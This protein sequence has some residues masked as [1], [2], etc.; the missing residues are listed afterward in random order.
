MILDEIKLALA[1][2][3]TFHQT[4]PAQGRNLENWLKQANNLDQLVN[5]IAATLTKTDLNILLKRDYSHPKSYT[6]AFADWIKLVNWVQEHKGGQIANR[7]ISH[8]AAFIAK[9][10]VPGKSLATIFSQIRK[11]L[12]LWNEPH[13]QKSLYLDHWLKENSHLLQ[14][15]MGEISKPLIEDELKILL[16][17]SPVAS[18]QKNLAK[19]FWQQIIHYLNNPKIWQDILN[20]ASLFIK[21]PTMSPAEEPPKPSHSLWRWQ[22]LPAG[23]DYHPE[24]ATQSVALPHGFKLIAARVRGKKHKHEGTHC[25]DWF[26]ITQ[27]GPWGIIAVADG[28][29]SRM[30]SR[31][32]ARVAC[33]AASKFLAEKLHAHSLRPRENWSVET[34]ARHDQTYQFKEVDLEF[35]HQLL[36]EAFLIAYQCLET[37]WQE[38]DELKHYYQALGNRDLTLNDF[39]TTLL[40]AVHTVVKVKDSD[41]SLVLTCQVGDGL[42]AAIYKHKAETSVLSE[43]ERNSFGGETQFVTTS[44]L[45]RAALAPKTFAFFSPMRA[46]LVM[47]DGVADDY[48]PPN[49]GMLKLLGDLI[50]NGIIGI[51]PTSPLPALAELL[52]AHRNEYLVTEERLM[53]TGVTPTQIGLI[54]PYAKLVK[55]SLEELIADPDCLMAGVPPWPPLA[56]EIRLQIW[57][58]TYNLRGSFDDRTLVVLYND[59]R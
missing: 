39:A 25:D 26:E 22:P 43:I 54:S 29:G 28:A 48:F 3:L 42:S 12:Y 18:Q 23:K 6:Q 14:Q 17:D 40:L 27:S 16:G 11:R 36:H 46:L 4:P 33:Q 41:Y 44:R 1:W 37:A 34:F 58:D 21:P 30:F 50:L 5:V 47:S 19:Q 24:S 55:R 13:P 57:L 15:L 52:E 31:V 56:P 53:E 10:S 8:G 45:E 9:H 49:Q 35:T 51:H 20:E 7:T 38:R 32:G 2:K 59:K